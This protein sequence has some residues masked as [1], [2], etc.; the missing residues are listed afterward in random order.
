M[1]AK[2]VIVA[3]SLEEETHKPLLQLKEMNIGP[4]AEIHLVHVVP[5][6]IYARGM[7]L[8]VL[9][10]PLP[11]ERPK[12]EESI[13]NK[14]SKIKE[15]IFPNH[16]NVKF[17]CLFDANEKAAF[18]DYVSEQHADLVVVATRGRHGLKNFFD[19]SFAQHQLKH[20]PAN[21]LVL[22]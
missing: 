11:E 1:K 21:V 20:A 3:V 7:Q 19:S 4:E 17:K 2:K 15:E 8:S 10:Y 13:L 16:Q 14:L 12:I 5:T 6:I 9:T 22:R 18:N